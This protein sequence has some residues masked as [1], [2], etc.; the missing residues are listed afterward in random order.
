VAD[1]AKSLHGYPVFGSPESGDKAMR[2]IPLS[3]Q[4]SAGNVCLV[5]APW[6]DA[7]LA[8][9]ALFPA[10]TYKDQIDALSRAYAALLSLGGSGVSRVAPT[11]FL[12]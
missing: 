10:S 8:E 5:R 2:A 9:A 3:A 1:L 11:L 12:N 7:L 6:N 4:V